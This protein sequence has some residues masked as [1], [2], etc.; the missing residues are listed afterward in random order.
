MVVSSVPARTSGSWSRPLLVEERD[1]VAAVVHGDLRVRVGDRVRG[2]RSRCRCPRRGGRRWRSRTRRRAPPR[3]RPAWTAGCEAARCDLGAA[4][5]ERP[6]QVR[7]LGGDVEAGRDPQAGQRPLALEALA[8][9][10]QDGHLALGPLDPA[11][12]LVGEAEV[13]DVVRAAGRSV[14]VMAGA[15]LRRRRRRSIG[16]RRAGLPIDCT[17]TGRRRRRGR[18][19]RGAARTGAGARRRGASRPAV[20]WTSRSSKRHVLAVAERA[21]RLRAPAGCRRGR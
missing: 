20:R 18:R 12:A 17:R 19:G 11:D 9:Q 16:G 4:G 6:H 7:G 13:G 5:R 3:R 21:V 15:V 10:A 2:A 14:S 8:D 1:E